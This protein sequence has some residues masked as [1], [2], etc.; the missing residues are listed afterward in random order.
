MNVHPEGM[1]HITC[2]FDQDPRLIAGAATI[3]AHVARHAGLAEA[4]ATEISAAAADACGAL[5]NASQGQG[6]PRPSIL[7]TA[8][9]FPDRIEVTAEAVAEAQGGRHAK[10]TA[11]RLDDFTRAIRQRLQGACIDGLNVDV[12]DGGAKVTLVKSSSST[13]RRFAL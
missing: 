10:A 5:A 7:L 11:G 1:A 8:S 3:V 4:A 6:N 9:E 13:K 2:K 12:R